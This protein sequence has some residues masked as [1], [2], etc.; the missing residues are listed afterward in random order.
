[1]VCTGVAA[2]P[3]PLGARCE[4]GRCVAAY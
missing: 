2:C 1:V 4:G 3:H